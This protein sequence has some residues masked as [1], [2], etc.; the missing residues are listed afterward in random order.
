VKFLTH[1]CR[2]TNSQIFPVKYFSPYWKGTSKNKKKH[3]NRL[4]ARL[5]E[6]AKN[7]VV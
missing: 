3:I 6:C 4:A 5:A 2:N 7:V 1:A